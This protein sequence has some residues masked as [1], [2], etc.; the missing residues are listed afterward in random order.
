VNF[1]M[2]H[3]P[4]SPIN[5]QD[6]SK[7]GELLAEEFPAV[8]RHFLTEAEKQ[9]QHMEDAY[10][11]VS[12]PELFKAVHRFKGSCGALTAYRLYEH[13]ADLERVTSSDKVS[14]T[15][16]ARLLNAIQEEY[17]QVKTALQHY[18]EVAPLN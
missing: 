7:L 5:T 16:V 14:A 4:S 10:L 12:Y 1:L 8:V 13:C 3:P 18:L 9:I 17:Q 2:N 11:D 15:Q 6:L